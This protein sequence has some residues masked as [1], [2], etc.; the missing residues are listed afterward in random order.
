LA[1]VQTQPSSVAVPTPDG[2]RT[3]VNELG[4]PV[5]RRFG[6]AFE[7]FRDR[8]PET[9]EERRFG[10]ERVGLIDGDRDVCG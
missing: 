4:V 6:E 9:G 2:S 5:S 3:I 7:V 1:G 10:G 8:R